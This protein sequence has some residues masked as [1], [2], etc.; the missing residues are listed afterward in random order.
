M[1]RLPQS[2]GPMPIT[3]TGPL[4]QEILRQVNCM[5]REDFLDAFPKNGGY[6]WD[7]FTNEKDSDVFELFCY[8]DPFN[9]QLLV[10]WCMQ[11][12]ARQLVET[13]A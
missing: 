4:I 2:G 9:A 5:E 13:R 3:L 8:L 11:E 6:L 10:D 1:I 7:K 12:I